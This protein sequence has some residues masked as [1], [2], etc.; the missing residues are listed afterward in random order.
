VIT[1]LLAKTTT[2]TTK[3]KKMRMMMK[4]KL[5]LPREVKRPILLDLTSISAMLIISSL[6]YNFT[7]TTTNMKMAISEKDRVKER[8]YLFLVK[9]CVRV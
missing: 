3:K 6:N 4:G 7:P 1:T 9:D 2:I 8:E 5:I